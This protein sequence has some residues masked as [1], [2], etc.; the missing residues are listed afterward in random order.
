M[1]PKIKNKSLLS[2]DELEPKEMEQLLDLGL[3]LKKQNKKGFW[4]PCLTI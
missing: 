2:L 4:R 3:E 1:K